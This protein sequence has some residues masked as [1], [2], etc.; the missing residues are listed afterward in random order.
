MAHGGIRL[1]RNPRKARKID[2]RGQTVI[3]LPIEGDAVVVHLS[4]FETTL[5][6]ILF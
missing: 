5:V 3:D 2:A 6:E 4:A 1:F